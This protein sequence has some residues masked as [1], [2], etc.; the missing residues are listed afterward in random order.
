M[1]RKAKKKFIRRRRTYTGEEDG[2]Q[3]KYVGGG[4]E[5]ERK[6]DWKRKKGNKPCG[7]NPSYLGH[8]RRASGP[9]CVVSGPI[10]A[11]KVKHGAPFRRIYL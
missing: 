8:D 3:E 1:H 10:E 2:G 11:P 7:L 5:R 4:K 9:Y 6:E